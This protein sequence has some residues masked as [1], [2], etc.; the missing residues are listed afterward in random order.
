[1]ALA[2]LVI[3]MR[4]TGPRT[5]DNDGVEARTRDERGRKALATLAA[6]DLRISVDDGWLKA[7]WCPV[8]FMIFPGRFVEQ[9]WRTVLE[10]MNA[11]ADSLE[12]AG[13]QP[14]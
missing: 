5:L 10:A 1:M 8:G 7:D 4:T 3:A 9:K 14:R 13:G 2:I 12:T 11:A 6:S